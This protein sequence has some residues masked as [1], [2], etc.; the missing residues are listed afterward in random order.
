MSYRSYTQKAKNTPQSKPAREDQVPNNAGGYAFQVSDWQRLERFLTIGADSGTY[1]VQAK[2]LIKQN[3]EVVKRC[4]VEDGERTVK[5]VQDIS[6]DGRTIKPET[7]IFALALCM[8]HGDPAT[9]RAASLAVTNVCRTGTHILHFA[10]YVNGL[11]GW[12]RGLRR[13]IANWY[14]SRTLDGLAYQLVKYQQRDGWS[15]ADLIR[16]AHPDPKLNTYLEGDPMH[17]QRESLYRWTLKGYEAER[18]YPKLVTVFEKAK[19]ADKETLVALIQDHNLTHEMIP[20]QYKTDPDVMAA[21]SVKMPLHA[22]VRQ[23]GN[24]SKAGLLVPGSD[25]FKLVYNKLTGEDLRK[26]RLHPISIL[27]ALKTYESGKGV[28]GHG[29]WPVTSQIVDALNDAFYRSF[30]NVTPTLKRILLGIDISGSMKNGLVVGTPGFNAAEAA[31]ALA[32]V[33][34]N[35]EPSCQVMAFDTDIYTPSFSARQR[36]DD[37]VKALGGFGGGSTDCALPIEHAI[38]RKMALDAIIILTDSETWS[39]GNGHPYQRMDDYR[40]QLNRPDCKLIVV[41]A[42]ANSTSI[43]DPK[44]A[45]TLTVTGFDPTVPQVIAGFLNL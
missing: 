18:K 2:D 11:R 17:N 25:T 35:T 13:A 29:E 34:M 27:V 39:G 37:V 28:R 36:L 15:H 3:A 12:G 9:R 31:T 24:L 45:N 32:L 33:T 6:V 38:Q 5:I 41:S 20:S 30:E 26:S 7:C 42:C 1:Y 43:G 14:N 44:D 21:L 4:I 19:T 23:L 10:E 40:H 8:A 22:M 16:L